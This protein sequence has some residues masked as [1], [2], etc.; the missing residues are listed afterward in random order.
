MF[1]SKLHHDIGILTMRVGIGAT[2]MVH[3]FPK[4]AGGPDAWLKLGKAISYVGIE[5]W[6][7]FFGF[8]A[9]TSEFIGGLFLII[10][11]MMRQASFLMC[12]TMVVATFMHLGMEHE[13]KVY[14]HS[15]KMAIVFLGLML[16]G[17]GRISL[18]KVFHPLEV[19]S[20]PDD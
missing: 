8:M 2:F 11:L 18:D 5:Q 20:E 14:S 19:E 9:A 15:L 12:C 10:G 16:I 6:F 7:T 4:L 17:P 3:G 13:F 1:A